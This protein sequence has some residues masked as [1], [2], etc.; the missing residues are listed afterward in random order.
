MQQARR[1]AAE[2]DIKED[3][4]GETEQKAKRKQGALRILKAPGRIIGKVSSVGQAGG[5]SLNFALLLF[6]LFLFLALSAVTVGQM[7]GKS[8]LQLMGMAMA[9]QVTVGNAA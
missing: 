2:K 8:R 3:Q 1:K 9:G 7:A 4:K 6:V 5:L